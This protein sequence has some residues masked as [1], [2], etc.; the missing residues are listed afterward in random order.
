MARPHSSGGYRHEESY[1]RR[2]AGQS[3][4]AIQGCSRLHKF[5]KGQAGRFGEV[6]GPRF[7]RLRHLVHAGRRGAVQGDRRRTRKRPTSYTNKW[8]NVAVVT[9]GTRVLGLGDIGPE[10]G[11]P[12]MEG[13]APALQVPGRR[14]RLPDLPRHEGPRQ[15]HRDRARPSSP[16]FGGYQP[17]GHLPAQVLPDPRHAA[18][19]V[20]RS[21]SGTTTSRAR[22]ASPWPG[23]I[24]ALKI[25]RKD[26]ARG[27]DAR[28]SASGAA[29]H[30]HRP[31][32]S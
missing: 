18:R 24:N 1:G 28:S 12:V 29:E 15:D 8:N 10:A 23:S 13:K 4:A 17:R 21:R 16:T 19:G 3:R 22:P 30:Q 25:V 7:Q 27:Q 14:R 5:Y 26:I 2:A 20:R 6:P 31:A 32:C 11:L 9:D